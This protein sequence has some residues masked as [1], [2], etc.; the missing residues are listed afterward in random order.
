M[1]KIQTQSFY[2]TEMRLLEQVRDRSLVDI[3]KLPSPSFVEDI[4]SLD[5]HMLIVK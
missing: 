4:Y 2:K 5:P 1:L 3:N